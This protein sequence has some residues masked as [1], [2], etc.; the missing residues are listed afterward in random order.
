MTFMARSSLL[1]IFTFNG[2]QMANH[3]S[4]E[5]A[6]I[7]NTEAQLLISVTPDRSLQKTSGNMSGHRVVN[8]DLS[9]NGNP[10]KKLHNLEFLYLKVS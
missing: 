5:K 10:A 1:N 2:K 9:S 7:V 3:L 6:V 8:D 4:T